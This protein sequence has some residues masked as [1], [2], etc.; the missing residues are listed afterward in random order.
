M[1][2]VTIVSIVGMIRRGG[3]DRALFREPASRN[4]IA[5]TMLTQNVKPRECFEGKL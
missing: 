3:L 1:I 2:T 4:H 5:Q